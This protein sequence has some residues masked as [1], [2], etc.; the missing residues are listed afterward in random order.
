M[1][2][3]LLVHRAGLPVKL[4]PGINI[5]ELTADPPPQPVVPK[6]FDKPLDKNNDEPRDLDPE[7]EHDDD[8]ADSDVLV[9]ELC[10]SLMDDFP[11]DCPFTFLYLSSE[12][13]NGKGE[14]ELMQ[15]ELLEEEGRKQGVGHV[16]VTADEVLQSDGDERWKWMKAGRTELDNLKN[17]GT[18]TAISSEKKEELRR[19]ARATGQQFVELPSK[20]V[21]TIKPDKY[22]VRIVACG[23]KIADT[24]GRVSTTDLDT[25]ML[26]YILSWSASSPDFAL[27]TLDVTAAFLNAP[28]PPGRIVVL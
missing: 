12:D 11:P 3:I 8:D 15:D 6:V 19:E 22:K 16:P 24:Y 28:L 14:E 25:T 5:D 27:A 18:V 10:A 7:P 13:K 9:E 1:C 23:N 26:R 21:F 2:L 4:P 20:G 17:T